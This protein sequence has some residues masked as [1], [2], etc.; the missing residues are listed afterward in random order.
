MRGRAGWLAALCGTFDPLLRGT[1]FAE[2]LHSPMRRC[3]DAWL[4]VPGTTHTA[5]M[6]WQS[7]HAP[8]S[9][10]RACC[11]TLTPL[12]QVG[13]CV[14]RPSHTGPM[15]LCL[16]VKMPEGVWHLD[17]LEQGKV[18]DAAA[19]LLA[20]FGSVL[21]RAG[22]ILPAAWVWLS[23]PRR[24]AGWLPGCHCCRTALVRVAATCPTAPLP[25]P[26]LFPHHSSSPTTPLPQP[27]LPAHPAH[28]LQ[29]AG[30]LKLGSSLL[31]EII[32]GGKK[33]SYEDLDE[34]RLRAIGPSYCRQMALCWQAPTAPGCPSL[35]GAEQITA[36]GTFAH[37]F[38]I[39]SV[40]MCCRPAHVLLP[41]RRLRLAWLSRCSPT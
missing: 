2:R 40:S 7:A 14:I 19:C 4:G 23:N 26:L 25:P 11:P 15:K 36:Q 3:A 41:C 24:P 34:V 32:P 21:P 13:E 10:T 18:G 16:T 6:V 17:L 39:S 31:C 28:N 12:P 35:V 8:H 37:P 9:P 5:R 30:S 1:S 20:C 22:P 29:P 33:E 27:L 38:P